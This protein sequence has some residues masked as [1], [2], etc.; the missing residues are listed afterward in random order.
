MARWTSLHVDAVS[1][2]PTESSR[3]ATRRLLHPR[4][5]APQRLAPALR[6]AQETVGLHGI[7]S[8]GMQS[9]ESEREMPWAMA[10]AL[11]AFPRAAP[12]PRCAHSDLICACCTCTSSR[13]RGKERQARQGARSSA[14]LEAVQRG[15]LQAGRA[16]CVSSS[17]PRQSGATAASQL[18][19]CMLRRSNEGSTRCGGTALVGYRGC[20]CSIFRTRR[21]LRSVTSMHPMP[22]AAASISRC[23]GQLRS[24]ASFQ[25]WASAAAQLALGMLGIAAAAQQT[26]G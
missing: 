17:I 13:R 14:L 22:R 16:R 1:S 20:G 19:A 24:A 23:S 8:T 12:P 11:S 5:S 21:Q 7:D 6:R 18:H 9:S 15:Q 3:S 25:S 10:A 4:C 2:Q 26:R